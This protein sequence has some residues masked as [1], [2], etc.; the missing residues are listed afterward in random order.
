MPPI[1]PLARAARNFLRFK[2]INP[3]NCPLK[4]YLIFIGAQLRFQFL[5]LNYRLQFYVNLSLIDYPYNFRSQLIHNY[6]LYGN[7][8]N[9]IGSTFE[10][11]IFMDY[12]VFRAIN[13]LA[14][15]YR[16]LDSIMITIS[17]R[18]RYLFVFLLI[19]MWFRNIYYK[20]VTLHSLI[21]VVVTL[22]I[23][24]FIK[25]FYFKPRPFLKYWV[26]LLPPTPSKKN[27]SFPSK[28]TTLAFA[29]ATSV[30]FYNRLLGCFISILGFIV[31]F[32]RVWMG[33]HYP[34]D[35]IGSVLLGS[36]TA[37]VVNITKRVWSPFLEWV[38]YTY[39][40][41]GSLVIFR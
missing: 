32:S 38:I 22:V 12:R 31:G 1:E 3:A 16:L 4:E 9:N 26:N 17:Q 28:H 20:K 13:Q 8:T 25:L 2:E 11:E 35:I 36:L 21:S 39:N 7:N 29:V 19:L 10:G 23:I 33:Q 41:V 14:G 18:L 5:F 37:I 34:S 30:L 40:R 27:S 24:S 15:R 6:F